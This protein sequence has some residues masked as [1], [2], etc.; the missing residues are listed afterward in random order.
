[1]VAPKRRLKAAKPD[2]EGHVDHAVLVLAGRKV[3]GYIGTNL[4]S[5][6]RKLPGAELSD[7]DK[8]F[9]KSVN[10]LRAVVE[11]AIANLET[12]RIL[13][14]ASPQAPRAGAS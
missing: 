14:T 10:T 1:M 3:I 7:H 9:N 2:S 13:D 12:C 4:I 5:P 8:D 11:R 6:K